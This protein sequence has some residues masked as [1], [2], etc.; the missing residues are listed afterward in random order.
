MPYVDALN[1]SGEV[2]LP[3]PYPLPAAHPEETEL[4]MSWLE[5]P[6][7]RLIELDGTWAWPIAGAAQ[8]RSRLA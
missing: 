2:V 6:G 5:Q 7:T 1:L 8:A 4:V 3:N